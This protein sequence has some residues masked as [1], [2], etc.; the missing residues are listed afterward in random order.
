[1]SKCQSHDSQIDSEV[2][3]RD[4]TGKKLKISSFVIV[5]DS[6][7]NAQQLLTIVKQL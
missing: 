7:L 4:D 2:Q 3:V 5:N 6:K 1:M